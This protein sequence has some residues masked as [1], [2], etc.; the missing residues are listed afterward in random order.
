MVQNPTQ[1]AQPGDTP[2]FDMPQLRITAL[3]MEYKNSFIHK[4]IAEI[5]VS[6]GTGPAKEYESAKQGVKRG[7]LQWRFNVPVPVA[8]EIVVKVSRHHTFQENEI[9][10]TVSV[11]FADILKFFQDNQQNSTMDI[12]GQQGEKLS[13]SIEQKSIKDMLQR[14]ALPSAVLEKLGYARQPVEALIAI[15]DQ[16]GEVNSIA[17]VVLGLFSK[18]YEQ[19]EKQE[20][21]IQ[22]VSLLFEKI[23]LLAPLL[24]TA[25]ELEDY[26]HLQKVIV[27]ILHLFQDVL[28][29]ID[30]Y[31]EGHLMGQIMDQFKSDPSLDI[32]RFSTRFDNLS[33]AFDQSLQV[34]QAQMLDQAQVESILSK[35]KP[36]FREPAAFCAKD[37]CSDIFIELDR[38]A[39]AKS[40]KIFWLHGVAG[41]GKST[42]AATYFNR[43]KAQKMLTGY[44][45]CS[46]DT[47]IHQSPIQLVLNLC[48]HLA[49]AYKP[50]SRMVVKAIKADTSFTPNSMP[51]AELFDHFILQ[52]VK[53]LQERQYRPTT[54]VLII[55]AL[56][57]CGNNAGERHDVIQRLEELVMCCDWIKV[58]ITSRPT[59]DVKKSLLKEELRMWS[60]DPTK[61]DANIEQFYK[62][63]FCHNPEFKDA[64]QML[65]NEIS[66][67][68]KQAGG[69]FIWAKTACNYLESYAEIH[70]AL[71]TLLQSQAHQDIY[72]LYKTVLLDAISA[73]NKGIYQIVMSAILLASEPLSEAGLG[74]LLSEDENIKSAINKV[75]SKLKGLIYI[76]SN[77][78]VYII[79]PSLREYLTNPEVCPPAY[80]IAKNQHYK[81]FERTV[82][83]MHKQLRFNICK[84]ESSYE[85]NE[86][87]KDLEE[88]ISENISEELGYSARNWMYH[89]MN[90]GS[91]SV[92]HDSVLGLLESGN[93]WLYWI[94]VLS[95][96]GIVRKTMLEM[97]TLIHWMDRSHEKSTHKV[98]MEEITTF[99]SKAV[100]AGQTVLEVLSK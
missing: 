37:T 5:S 47:T 25:Q 63:Q 23:N 87:V 59:V 10:T 95:L 26:E 91:W 67:L 1:Q 100:M 62:Y 6:N 2:R 71:K 45:I 77:N 75:L 14:V 27:D 15:S 8:S 66:G 58:F 7:K 38:W 56:D 61:N 76:G 79:H 9:M 43:L 83:V 57:E 60:L 85:T 84:L 80:Y 21:C 19:L 93:G 97:T 22:Q 44:H 16:L 64:S 3:N 96:L 53:A 86:E 33:K 12:K 73:N 70:I 11:L 72:F 20:L 54:I 18:V 41:M 28:N 34:D 99:L 88:R 51:V 48:Y 68:T 94:E 40:E 30:K 81:L 52:S 82:Q 32:Q 89:T 13:L 24:A 55:D 50:F 92:A 36:N 42:I 90:T 35:L 69:L 49:M 39:M 17:K 46:R 29:A 4:F 98:K 78:C 74:R 31:N 65:L